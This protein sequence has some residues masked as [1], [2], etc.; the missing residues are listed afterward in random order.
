MDEEGVAALL[1]EQDGVISRRQLLQLSG[2]D[3]DIRRLV[4][5]RRWARVHEG[6]Y[7]DHTGPLTERQRWWAAVLRCAPAALAGHSALDAHGLRGHHRPVE[8]VLVCISAHRFIAPAPGIEIV[9][10]NGFTT[11]CQLQLSPPRMRLDEALIVEAGRCASPSAA[12]ATLADAVQLRRTTTARLARTLEGRRRT[13]HRRLLFTI[14]DDVA[15]GAYSVLEQRY[16]NMVERP[17]GL[18]V[19][20]RQRR[21]RLGKTKAY[22][23]VDYLELGTTVEL[24]GRIGHEESLDRWADL[25]RDLATVTA[26]GLTLRIGWGQVLEPCRLAGVVAAILA[27]RGWPRVPQRCGSDCAAFQSSGD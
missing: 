22:R 9:R 14:L 15:S 5:Q 20:D 17:H 8:P 24:D 16:L 18:P 7:V 1:V 6:V 2:T 25:D 27:A 3:N 19:A 10:I 23:D 13:R 12:L 21:V 26:G 4:R 11:R